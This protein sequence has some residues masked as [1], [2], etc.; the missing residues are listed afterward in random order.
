MN[1]NHIPFSIP[2]VSDIYEDIVLRS[3]YASSEAVTEPMRLE[4]VKSAEIAILSIN[5]DAIYKTTELTE[6]TADS[7]IG[8]GLIIQSKKL[9]ALVSS[10][11]EPSFI[12][13]FALTLGED[14]SSNIEFLQKDSMTRA[15]FVDAAGSVLAE[16]YAMQVENY[17][18]EIMSEKDLQISARFSPGYCDW[19]TGV[20]Q[21]AFFQFLQPESIGIKK[22][23]SG[24]ML[25][26]KSISGTIIAA[27]SIDHRSPCIFCGKVEC[28]YRRED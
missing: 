4:I 7:V 25:P 8:E 9:A 12:T 24:M 1:S 5:P 27:R 2:E 19:E 15:F 26:E 23:S 11:V 16:K 22:L 21:D 20:G 14:L 6:A 17:I 13:A 28:P 10:F 18:S 3:G